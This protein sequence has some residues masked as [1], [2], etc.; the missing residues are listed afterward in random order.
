MRRRYV[1]L[2]VSASVD[3]GLL[4]H[5]GWSAVAVSVEGA[6]A[7]PPSIEG[8]PSGLVAVRRLTLTKLPPRRLLLKARRAF[9]VIALRPLSIEDARVAARSGLIDLISLPGGPGCFNEGVASL[10]GSSGTALELRLSPL[11]GAGCPSHLLSAFRRWYSL[12]KGEGVGVLFSTGASSSL[13]ARSP[14]DLAALASLITLDAEEATEA[15]S[16]VPWALIEQALSRMRG[17]VMP[18]V[19]VVGGQG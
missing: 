9:E 2:N 17:Y 14:R 4:R 15:L 1:D 13:E 6:R 5:L 3:L 12:A 18:G 19:R 7:E 10:M 16:K 8:A 11:I